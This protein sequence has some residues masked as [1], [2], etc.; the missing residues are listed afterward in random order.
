MALKKTITNKNGVT[1]EYHKIGSLNV[2][3]RGDGLILRAVVKSY[4]TEDI[5]NED[6]SLSVTES[7]YNFPTTV[8]ELESKS[9]YA[10]AYEKLKGTEIFAEAEDC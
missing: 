10:L 8:K 1:T 9:I 4:V 5:R 2:N 6:M 7:V 3:T